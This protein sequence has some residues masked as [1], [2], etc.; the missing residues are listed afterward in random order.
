MN[1]KWCPG[2]GFYFFL[3]ILIYLFLTSCNK[4]F[5]FPLLKKKSE[6]KPKNL[7]C[8]CGYSFCAKCE[9]EAHRPLSCELLTSWNNLYFG[10]DENLNKAWL[11]VNT[12]KCPK[13]KSCI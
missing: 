5:Y 1:Y 10:K 9:N 2:P 11:E 7:K 13:C 12:K 6:I 4:I 8:H 3:F